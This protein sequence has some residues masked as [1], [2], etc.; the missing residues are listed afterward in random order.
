MDDN[1]KHQTQTHSSHSS[2]YEKAQ[3]HTVDINRQFIYRFY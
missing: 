1:A 2:P 3:L